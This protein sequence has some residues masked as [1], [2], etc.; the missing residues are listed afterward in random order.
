MTASRATWDETWMTVARAVAQRS[1]CSRD[2]VGAVIVDRDNRIVDTGYNGPPRGMPR[3]EQTDCRSWC[4]R[5]AHLNDTYEQM[6]GEGYVPNA[7][8]DDCPSLHAEANALMFS[9]RRL[10][11]GGTI[12]VTSVVCFGCAKLVANSGLETVVIDG[13]LPAHHR[14]GERSNEFMER[15]GLTVVIL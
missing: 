11:E 12:Y 4:S 1:L 9:D 6:H 15:C 7:N 3:N 2:R 13:A 10:R 8:Y 5:A 14:N